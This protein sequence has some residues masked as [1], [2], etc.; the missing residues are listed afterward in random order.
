M[1]KLWEKGYVV[2][3]L[4]EAFTTG[5]DYILDRRLLPSDIAASTAH[6]AMLCSIGVIS[7]EEH[8]S[9]KE[10]LTGILKDFEAGNF[11]VDKDDEDCHTAIENKLVAL[12]GTAGEKVHTG[13]SR[14]DQVLAAL[15]LFTRDFLLIF[16]NDLSALIQRLKIKALEYDKVPIPGRTHLQLA[17]P[18]SIGLW[19]ASFAENLLDL[20]E[21]LWT[22]YALNNQCPLGSAAS[23]GVPLGL[24]REMVADLLGFKKVQNNV[25]YVNNSRGMIELSVLSSLELIVLALNKLAS[26]MIL[27]SLPELAYLRLPDEICTGSSIMPNK[28][29]PDLLELVRAK[30]STVSACA[31]QVKSI[32]RSLASGY[33]RDFQETKEP[34]FRGMDTALRSLRVMELAVSKLE[35]N[36]DNCYRAFK[37]EVFATDRTYRLLSEGKSFREEYRL[38]AEEMKKQDKD[39]KGTSVISAEEIDRSLTLRS[40][41]GSPGNLRLDILERG[42][43]KL[44]TELELEASRIDGKIEE[45]LGRRLMFYSLHDEPR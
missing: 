19:L 6:A 9:I 41:Q 43:E 26:D 31:E 24:D 33:N 44:D 20:S 16:I 18:S 11:T 12:I 42:L 21:S 29:N 37:S 14:N 4:V 10:G 30:S 45:L 8:R 3:S 25:L 5:E 35:L 2:D 40:S 32:I 13:R 23:Y 28:K 39:K 38:I 34:F 1:A 7:R 22:N 36:I 27:F 17:M 15:R